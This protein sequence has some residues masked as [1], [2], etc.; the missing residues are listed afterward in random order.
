MLCWLQRREKR[1]LPACGIQSYKDSN[2]WPWVAE[3]HGGRD[4][5]CM[6][7]LVSLG[8][9]LTDTHCVARHGSIVSRLQVKLGRT[10]FGT[11]GQVSR[12]VSSIHYTMG[13]PLV[14]LQLETR[15]EM[16]ASALPVCLNSGPI[17]KDVP[18]WVLSWEDSVNRV[19]M[20]VPVFILTPK[21]CPYLNELTL[22]LGT[23]CVAYGKKRLDRYEVDLGSSLICQRGPDSWMLM[24]I[25]IRGSQELFAPVGTQRSW[26]SQTVRDA[27]FV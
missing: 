18:C 3:V 23:F 13:S 2:P 16:S 25:S 4:D 7:T 12:L 20:T 17:S 14:L 26:I 24:G 8:W 5:V 9:V 19:P 1:S 15:V 10:R 11:P 6:A 27:P 22:P 21:D